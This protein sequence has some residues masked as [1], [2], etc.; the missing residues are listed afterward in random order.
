MFIP[1]HQDA[2]IDPFGEPFVEVRF[3]NG[4]L[5]VETTD[6][7]IAVGQLR[8]HLV[9][10]ALQRRLGHLHMKPLIQQ[11]TRFAVSSPG[12]DDQQHRRPHQHRRYL[13]SR[14]YPGR[15]GG[16]VDARPLPIQVIPLTGLNH[17]SNRPRK[18][19][20][21]LDFIGRLVPPVQLRVRRYT[22]AL[23]M[24][25]MPRIDRDNHPA[26]FRAP[27]DFTVRV[28]FDHLGADRNSNR[29]SHRFPSVCT[30]P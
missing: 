14:V 15:L 24:I 17:I 30:C 8:R 11:P 13:T 7:L 27:L 19:T 4:R 26:F 5:R 10:P 18:P 28:V 3:V 16:K 2:V 20:Q 29:Q 23:I 21:F 25:L 22:Q 9:D 6:D 1:H 12:D